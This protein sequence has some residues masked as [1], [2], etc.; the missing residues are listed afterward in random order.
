M[1]HAIQVDATFGVEPSTAVMVGE[2][3][4]RSRSAHRD[5]KWLRHTGSSKWKR[6]TYSPS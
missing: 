5:P 4:L 2:W 6:I 1:R 3:Y